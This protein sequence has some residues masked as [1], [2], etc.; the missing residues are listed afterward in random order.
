LLVYSSHN[1]PPQYLEN[2]G[3]HDNF[4]ALGGHSLLATHI[5]FRL[6]LA[7]PNVDLPLRLFFETPTV[8]GIALAIVQ[9]LMGQ[10]AHDD[11]KRLIAEVEELSEAPPL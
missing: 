8:A 7:F 1:S 11:N 2:I 9:R 3:L 6:H 4:F 10:A 5:S